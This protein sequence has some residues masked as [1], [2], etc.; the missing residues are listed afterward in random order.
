MYNFII[1][2]YL[3]SDNV[4][5]RQYILY[6]ILKITL[7]DFKKEKYEYIIEYKILSLI[8]INF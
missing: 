8:F 5:L 2:I 1:M 4:H 6:A 3:S 7:L